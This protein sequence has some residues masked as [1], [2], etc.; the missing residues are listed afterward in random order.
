MGRFSDNSAKKARALLSCTQQAVP[1]CPWAGHWS[2]N[3]HLSVV[4]WLGLETCDLKV[5]CG[6]WALSGTTGINTIQWVAC[7]FAVIKAV[8]FMKPS[9]L[10]LSRNSFLPFHPTTPYTH[11][12]MHTWTH[13]HTHAHKLLDMHTH[14]PK[15]LCV[16]SPILQS[17]NFQWILWLNSRP[18]FMSWKT[19]LHWPSSC[20]SDTADPI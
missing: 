2:C 1:S 15:K 12:H 4:G 19:L 5:R 17:T 20:Y 7:H 14:T 18:H 10:L 11:S 6:W 13:I 8:L 16:L 9:C 3:N